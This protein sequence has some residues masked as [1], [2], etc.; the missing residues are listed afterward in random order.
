MIRPIVVV[1]LLALCAPAA[2]AQ[3]TARDQAL[4]C[5]ANDLHYVIGVPAADG[6]TNYRVGDFTAPDGVN[7]CSM[8]APFTREFIAE[9]GNQLSFQAIADD[10]LVLTESTGPEY[11]LE[12][13]D[14]AQ[15]EPI[16]KVD[17]HDV[18]PSELG[19]HYYETSE[20]ATPA[21]CSRYAELTAGGMGAIVG[22]D[23][24]FPFATAKVEPGKG[25]RCYQ[26]P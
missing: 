4:E 16:L 22:V 7:P 18:E 15:P 17:A 13:Y 21:T 19:I 24:F 1:A 9:D 5:H 20:P 6:G 14:L 26:T 3:A 8:D 2:F 10:L 25:S 23:R 11:F 12:I